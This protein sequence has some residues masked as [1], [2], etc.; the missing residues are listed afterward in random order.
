MSHLS[1]NQVLHSFADLA[2]VPLAAL[3]SPSRAAPICQARHMA[4]WMLRD[5]CGITHAEIGAM[6]GGR[7][8]ATVAEGIDRIDALMTIEHT[9]QRRVEH[10]R[11][12]ILRMYQPAPPPTT[13][14]V[15]VAAAVGVLSDTFLD[16]ADARHAALTILRSSH[17]A[18]PTQPLRKFHPCNNERA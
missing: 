1:P 9:I 5:L 7:T 17:L 18:S 16:D 3:Q 12:A 11:A 8:A 4:M 13:L 14:D 15:R 2:E 6:L 10:L